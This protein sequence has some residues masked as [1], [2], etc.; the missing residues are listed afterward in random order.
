MSQPKTN[1]NN[2]HEKENQMTPQKQTEAMITLQYGKSGYRG[3]GRDYPDYL[4]DHNAVQRVIDGLDEG[5]CIGLRLACI[6]DCK[7][8][9]HSFINYE[10]ILRA[11]CPQKVEAI[12][13]A[14][15]L[16][17]PEETP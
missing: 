4:H 7:E 9:Y 16:W 2:T 14:T 11:T 3:Y 1:G 6:L 13:K 5:L 17:Q 15:G 8:D 10:I 12:L